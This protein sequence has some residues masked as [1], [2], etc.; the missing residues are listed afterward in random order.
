MP[1]Q[2]A[3]CTCAGKRRVISSILTVPA[4]NTAIDAVRRFADRVRDKFAVYV[5]GG[6]EAQ[7]QA[8]VEQLLTEVG[9]ALGLHVVPRNESPVDEVGGRPD[10]GVAV[11]QLLAGHLEL[12]KPG[13]GARTQRFRGHDR[14][15]WGRFQALPNLT[16][17]DGQEWALY[18]TGEQINSTVKLGDIV[19]DGAAAVDEA[20]AGR[21]VDMLRDFLLW[22]PTVPASPESLAEL[23][24]PLCGVVRAD[25]LDAL[26]D[27]H[28]AMSSL[29]RDWRETLFPEA[30]NAQFADAYA[31]T[32]TYALLLA[33]IEG[34]TDVRVAI[35]ADTLEGGH[36][37]LAEALRILGHPHARAEIATGVDLLERVIMAVDRERLGGA[38]LWVYFYEHFLAEYDPRLRKDRG[39]YYTP[40]AVIRCQVRLADELLKTRLER[41]LGF[42][43]DNVVTLDPGCGTASYLLS[44][45]DRGLDTVEQRWGRG[46]RGAR[47][48]VMA[49]NL[50]GFEILVGPYAVAHMMLTQ[51]LLDAGANLPNEGVRVYLTDTLESPFEEDPERLPLGLRT[52]AT[53]HRRALQVKTQTRVLVCMG[54]PPYDR[55][56]IAPDQEDVT[57]R[58]GGWVRFGDPDSEK[59]PIL[60]DL[61]A[62]AREAGVGG[63]LK[64]VYNDYVYFWRWAMWKVLDQTDGP[65]IVTFIT[66]ASYLRGP[67]FVGLRKMMRETFDQLWIIDLEGDQLGPRKT[68]NVFA[69]ATPVAIAVGIRHAEPRPH[70]PATVWYTRLDGD[71]PAKLA[72]LEAIGTFDDVAW[73]RCDDEWLAPL[74]PPGEGDFFSWPALT[75]LFPWQHSGVQMKRTWVIAPDRDTLRIRW[76]TLLGASPQERGRLMR[77]T[78]ARHPSRGYDR[79]DGKGRLPPLAELDADTVPEQIVRYPFRS[80]DRQWILA[81]PRL[82]DRLRPPL[83]F[84]AGSRQLF[85]TSLLTQVMGT[86]PAATVASVGDAPPDLHHFRGSYGA[87]DVIPMWR[88][89]DGEQPNLTDGLLDTLSERL[90]EPVDALDLFCYC[91]AIL[92][93]PSYTERFSEELA[94]PGPRV[95]LTADLALF[96]RG[97]Q[98]GR[99][100]VWWHTY[101]TRCVPDGERH[102]AVP[103]GQA[104]CRV[105][106]PST[107]YPQ[108]FSFDAEAL[109]LR[110]GEG[111]VAPVSPAVWDFQVS[112]MHVLYSWLAYRTAEGAGRSSSDLDEIR[113]ARWSAPMT[114]ELLELI[115]MLERTVDAH[116]EMDGL[117]DAVLDA[118]VI[119]AEDLPMPRD[120]EREPPT[121]PGEGSQ[122]ALDLT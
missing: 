53:E 7:L 17:T 88:D 51:A 44:V 11:A 105:G 84:V 5:P 14:E 21:L 83:W 115:W 89:P 107:G 28:S 47:A 118:D 94:I 109:T 34:A 121:I 1:R 82:G 104:E 43:D 100:L 36:S 30:D 13:T 81:D 61:L 48:S 52:L 78:S 87:K 120:A 50:H 29:A 86:G 74:T 12:K 49:Q 46:H 99:Q 113:A 26:D 16:Y 33:R 75:D 2:A 108:E 101:G 54:N 64:N 42:A 55:Q 77:K 69:I 4:S 119:A 32:L 112:G 15:Q 106:V 117:L 25:V 45:I 3:S 122:E 70:E 91:Y 76:Q 56:T 40:P 68:S 41:P 8:P 90:G 114:E 102:G 60:E 20:A 37:L 23:L 103:R 66:A 58:K 24:A 62:P 67:G 59:P 98:L 110:V 35:A 39:V 31:Q 93:N 95:P 79:L 96:R 85:L 27:Q 116:G 57:E 97:A 22:E 9:R 38:D 63:H 65:G 92:A 19:D 111:E 6:E 73:R 72:G 10:F 18:R 80:F 71:E